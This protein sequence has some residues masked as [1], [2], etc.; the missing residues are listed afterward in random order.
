MKY[1]DSNLTAAE[2]AEDLLSRM[3]LM[4]KVGQL[5]QKLYGFH[6]Y[7]RHGEEIVLSEE[8]K[9]EVHRYSGLGVLYGLY[10]A[11]P[12]SGRDFGNG[13]I[14]QWA[15]KAYNR[16]QEYVL[17]HSRLRIPFLLSTE[18]PHGHQALGGYLLP[19]NL[20]LGASFRP[21]LVEEAY[22]VCGRQ[23]KE[24]GV[25]LAL[26]SVLDVLRDPRWGRSE[27]C[28]GEDPF[29]AAELAKAAV[30]GIQNQGVY[31]VAKH[32]C[33]QGEGSGGINASAARIGERELREIH[34]VPM[35]ACCEAKVKGVMAAYNEI[36]GIYCHASRHLLTGVLREE[37]GFEG[38]VMSDGIAV[39][40][41]DLMTGDSMRSGAIA[42]K[43]GVTVGLWDRS[44][45]LLGE[46]V[47]AGF[48]AMEELDGAVKRV[49]QMK[50][51]R[52]LFEH[53]YLEEHK[54]WLS[55]SYDKYPQSLQLARE[56][57]VLLKNEEGILPL[58][59]AKK[60]KIAVIGPNA[61]EIYNQLGD[62]TPP[63]RAEDGVTVKQGILSYVAEHNG[64]AE[65]FYEK[66][67][68]LYREHG[69][70]IRKAQD[71]VKDCD[72]AVLVLGGSSSRFGEARF[73]ANGAAVVE[74]PAAMDCGEG[75]D[76]ADLMLPAVQTRLADALFRTG[77][78][79]ITVMI[80]G[81]PYA[82]PEIADK[83]RALLCAFYPGIKGGQAVA[84]ILFG[85]VDPSGRL[86]VSIPRH[87]GQLPVYYNYK[88]SY[89][90]MRYCD[91]EQTPLF[92]FGQ[93]FGY[94]QFSYEHV[95]LERTS[96]SGSELREQ[97]AVLSFTLR[98][99]GENQGYAVPQLY[100]RH[101]Q[102]QTVPRVR[103]LKAF[104]KLFLRAGESCSCSLHITAEHLSVWNEAMEFTVLAGE[105][106]IMLCDSGNDIKRQILVVTEIETNV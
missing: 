15:A 56:S 53:P 16:I 74:G 73:D 2:R 82:I 55:Y 61:H 50:F 97:G 101:L 7:E 42:L 87:S 75:V 44:F 26:V 28:Y 45:G 14:G 27:E 8:L 86:P 100:I 46:A 31:V 99:T 10:R 24:M 43:A 105:K 91:M 78:P 1:R 20:A 41:L 88:A 3:T 36:D 13:L 92:A 72:V 25:D 83:S 57:V 11:D 98:N 49:L 30:K 29:L 18:C 106:E 104:K 47:Q 85:Q 22:A 40:Q 68:G 102:S 37:M 52:G 66:G 60:Q 35:K 64:G 71:L 63:V 32:F 38:I 9:E 65:V 93:G 39:D 19:V 6:A 70:A 48:L 81:R 79:V 96:I 89:R 34:Y 103:E 95:R 67:C 51:E 33:A 21:E 62:Y 5:N 94:G 12:W 58:K 77:T 17:E 84:E 23:M 54:T 69:E 59:A 76:C 4:E 90:A 80:Q